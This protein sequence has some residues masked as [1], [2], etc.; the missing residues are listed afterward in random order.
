MSSQF[1]STD[2]VTEFVPAW[3][4]GLASAGIAMFVLLGA[5]AALLLL[6]G[7]STPARRLRT[8]TPSLRGRVAV[9][10]ILV[11]TLPLISLG[12]VLTERDAHGQLEYIATNLR[13]E[14]ADLSQEIAHLLDK[15]LGSMVSLA[16]H[17]ESRGD[18]SKES[19][20]LWLRAQHSTN[21]D[22]LTMLAANRDG[23]IV[24]ATGRIDGSIKSFPNVIDG[25]SDREYFRRPMATGLPYVSDVFR[26]R[27]LGNDIIVAISAPVTRQDGE[28]WG[29]VEGSLDLGLLAAMD[30]RS[31]HNSSLVVLDESDRVIY[32]SPDAALEVLRPLTGHALLAGT[33]GLSTGTPYS[34]LPDQP[35]AT[36]HI[37]VH[38]RVDNGWQLFTMAPVD[39]VE[40]TVLNELAVTAAWLAGAIIVAIWLALAFANSVARPLKRLEQSLDLV[41]V[42]S[43]A[44]LPK[45]SE[46][47]PREVQLVYQKIGAALS[48]LQNK[49]ERLFKSL[50]Q[51][52]KL[53][54]KL[55]EILSSRDQEIKRQ[56]QQL[57]ETNMALELLNRTDSLTGLANRQGFNEFMTQV[58]GVATREQQPVSV[59]CLDIDFFKSYNDRYG[60]PAGDRALRKVAGAINDAASRPL[61]H[62]ARNGGEEFVAVLGDTPLDSALQVA[63]KMRDGVANLHIPHE[64]SKVDNIVTISI[65]VATMIPGRDDRSTELLE[66]GDRALYAAKDGGRNQVVYQKE[67]RHFVYQ[68]AAQFNRDAARELTEMRNGSRK[69]DPKIVRFH[70]PE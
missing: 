29:I 26:G 61:D 15:N 19:L 38:Q 52:E 50:S 24:V 8:L 60:H 22:F 43:G 10:F 34:Y 27:G 63:E 20:N 51:T 35:G 14:A 66:I 48:S 1:S 70:A 47:A 6:F 68:P 54:G 59:I 37:A 62:V 16:S 56:T 5:L 49:N 9:G 33:R 40:A 11:A 18:K 17:I 3:L 67:S 2:L 45:V 69:T 65:G 30:Q 58:W 36:R 12:I 7:N 25:I 55:A 64:G 44:H 4:S 39:A 13:G 21:P 46:T 31:R 32:A 41:N 28:L 23:Q 57:R 53:R 42:D